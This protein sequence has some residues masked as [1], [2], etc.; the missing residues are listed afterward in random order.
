MIAENKVFFRSEDFYG[1]CDVLK[2]DEAQ[3]HIIFEANEGNKVRIFQQK[4]R[5]GKVDEVNGKTILYHRRTG[6]FNVDGSTNFR[7]SRLDT[8]RHDALALLPGRT[9]PLAGHPGA[10]TDQNQ[11]MVEIDRE[12]NAYLGH[13]RQM[14]HDVAACA[15]NFAQLERLLA[16]LMVDRAN[17]L[18]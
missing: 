16:E 3:D 4:V 11:A 9:L 13:D 15:I 5:G 10:C 7:S 8:N 12:V 1:L 18:G 17:R 14:F 6:E 2:F